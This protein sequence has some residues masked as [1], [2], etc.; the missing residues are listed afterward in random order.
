MHGGAAGSAERWPREAWLPLLA[1]LTWLWSAPG[2]GFVGFL[3]SVIPGCLLLGSGVAML[4]LS[5]DRRSAQWA[6]GGG[7]LG[8]LF[9]LPAFLV[10]GFAAGLLLV[11]VSAASFVAAGWHSIKLEL[12]HEAVPAPEL[13]VA[14]AAQVAIDEA[15]V[16]EMVSRTA[17]PARAAAED[18]GRE[19]TR[20]LDLFGARGWLAAPATFHAN[21][22]ALEAPRIERRNLRS[23]EFEHLSFESGYEPHAEEPGRDRWLGYARNRTAHAWV[24][25][26]PGAERPWLMCI[27]GYV[28]GWPL[29]DFAVFQ[30]ELFHEQLGLNLILP[31]LPLHGQRSMGRRSGEGFFGANVMD[32]LHAEAQAMWDLRRCLSW[33]R[34]QGDSRVGVYGLSLGG[35]NAALLAGLDEQLACVVAGVPVADFARIVHRHGPAI[36]IR[37]AEGAGLGE[38]RMREVKRVVSPLE[39]APQVPHAHRH[40]FAGVAD[41][42]VPPDH[43]RDLWR[44]WHEP[45]I[46]W[47]QGGHCSFRAH[48]QVA[49]M[50]QG[51]LTSAGLTSA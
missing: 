8:V 4:L 13:T 12:P 10:V 34:G 43:V 15:L 14:L 2:H 11:L 25:R 36:S 7:V 21:P 27:H 45:E 35:Y 39:L 19:L 30:P 40:L 37:T 5:G 29:V 23:R 50:L 26:H 49:R 1:G 3:F 46:V 18:L 24:L 17:M 9:A 41:R 16:A 6:A 22:P 44:H 20:A 47:Y 51:A 48:P 42:I 31:V 32:M 28:M 38:E 33:V